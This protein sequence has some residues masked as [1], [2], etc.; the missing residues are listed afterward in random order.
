ME[1]PTFNLRSLPVISEIDEIRIEA[2]QGV[3]VVWV[4]R[5]DVPEP[6]KRLLVITREKAKELSDKLSVLPDDKPL[7]PPGQFTIEYEELP[8]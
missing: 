8:E 7:P 3:I 4:S 2:T 6:P 5:P 1:Q